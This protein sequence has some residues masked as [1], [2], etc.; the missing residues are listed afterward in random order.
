MTP[1]PP[2][3][4]SKSVNDL[5]SDDFGSKKGVKSKFKTAKVNGGPITFTSEATEKKGALVAAVSAKW[6]HKDSGFSLTKATLCPTN[7]IGKLDF[8]VAKLPLSGAEVEVK[9]EP[10]KSSGSVEC[11]YSNDTIFAGLLVKADSLKYKSA[12]MS[13]SMGYDGIQVGGQ[14]SF[15]DS[16]KDVWVG[17][18]YATK[19]Y[20]ASIEAEKKMS[21]FTVKALAKPSGDLSV[22]CSA[23]SDLKSPP[24]VGAAAAYKLNSDM[25]LKGKYSVTSD[26]S[27]LDCAFNYSALSKVVL[28]GGVGIPMGGTGGMSFGCGLT[29]G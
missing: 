19:Q 16:L 7:G 15:T 13:T 24:A 27:K 5:L 11:T 28:V 12:T 8:K 25:T 26:A 4:F 6:E 9:T 17:L 22:A 3:D 20:F 23:T 14:V 18:G 21:S 10:S 1:P 29:L 2:V